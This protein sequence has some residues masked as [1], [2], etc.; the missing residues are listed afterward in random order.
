VAKEPEAHKSAGELLANWRS[1]ERDTIASHA[2]ATVAN[3]ALEA[4][5]AADEAATEV[6]AAAMA[7]AEAVERAR[8]AAVRAR[9][10]AL[11]AA[12]A[13]KMAHATAEGDKART[14]H[15]EK[16]AH[17]AE[18]VARDRFHQAQSEGFPKD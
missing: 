9:T 8:A 17:L 6:E 10:A 5:V 4:A 1:A 3:F 14:N 13:A 2:A 12:E 18:E 7:A 16:T 15:N 11:Q